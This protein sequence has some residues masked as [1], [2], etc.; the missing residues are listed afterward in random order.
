MV[1]GKS[2]NV[3]HLWPEVEGPKL[4]HKYTIIEANSLLVL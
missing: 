2:P 1:Y 3:T 4:M